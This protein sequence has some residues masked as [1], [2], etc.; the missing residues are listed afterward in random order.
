[1]TATATPTPTP[2]Q[3]AAITASRGPV[4]VVAGPGAGKTFCLIERAHHLIATLG[5]AADRVCAVTFTNK[6]AQEVRQRLRDRLGETAERITGG[7]LHALC[8]EILRERGNPVGV[9]RGFGIA[10]EAYQLQIL[11]RLRVPER[12]RKQLL[13]LFGR[14]RFAAYSLTEGDRRVFSQYEV[15]LRERRLLDF[16]ELVGKTGD[17]FRTYPVAAEEVAASWDA[18]LVDEFQDLD[19][20]QY[21]VIKALASGHRNIFA[22]GDDEQSIFAWRGAE[23]EILRQF[24]RDF[25]I[26]E[27]VVLDRNL[28]CSRR[29]FAVARRLL[30]ANPALFDKRIEAE[31]ESPY[32]VT[33]VEF[34]HEMEEAAWIAHDILADR[35]NSGL[36]LGEYAAL[37]RQHRHAD[38]LEAELLKAGVVCRFARGRALQDDPVIGYLIGSLKIALAPD[39]PALLVLFAERELPKALLNHVRAQSR[40]EGDDVMAQLRAFATTHPKDAEGKRAWRFIYH[41]DNLAAAARAHRSLPALVEALV[42]LRISSWENRLERESD[43]LLDPADDPAA[44]ALADRLIE[45]EREGRWVT[46][47][48]AGGTE[49]PLRSMLGRARVRRLTEGRKDG[50]TE[51][52]NDGTTEGR[53]DGGMDERADEWADRVRIVGAVD[54][55]ADGLP[56]T[57]FRA[58]QLR[59]TRHLGD[60]FQRFVT[61]DLETTGTDTAQCEIVEIGAARVIGDRIV[62]RFQSLVKP[63]GPIAREA[64]RIH[65]ITDQDVAAAPRFPEVWSAFRA[66]VKN[67][68]LVAHNAHQFDLPVLRRAA[69]DL[70][71]G[72]RLHAF[73]TLPVARAVAKGGA[74]LE[75]LAR[76]YGIDPGTSHR[77]LDDA[78]TL[79][80]VFPHLERA[81]IVRARK[82]ALV[83]LLD[84]LALALALGPE[85]RSEHAAFLFELGRFVALGPR[86]VSL[87]TYAERYDVATAI[88]RL[89]G[90]KLMERLRRERT[91]EDLYPEA[92]ERLR[93]F[94]EVEGDTIEEQVRRFLEVMA[95][96]TSSEGDVDQ[97][98][99]NLLTLH[100][101]KGLEFSRVYVVGVED[102]TLP[103]Y[104]AVRDKLEAEIQEGRRLLYVGMTRA[105]DRLVLTRT[106]RRN[107]W[108]RGGGRYLEEMGVEAKE[109]VASVPAAPAR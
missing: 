13:T 105:K 78:L 80:R 56:V 91:A 36:P 76:S 60:A 108:D 62:E 64:T 40:D 16:D 97:H 14:A 79:A 96:S 100:S 37:F 1:V 20:K 29:I 22:V 2:A 61:F 106:R 3:Q 23:P 43:R 109:P 25:G 51:G 74:R 39:D 103:G 88:E 101:T 52:R 47:E 70:P 63:G 66:F 27:P 48:A 21:A 50:R 57:L 31:R 89:G 5:V 95:L 9:E 28:R 90:Q 71:G 58:L 55:G 83:A 30:G 72:D 73:D 65:G 4:L 46:V 15:I 33:A 69:A 85:E 8:A 19:R 81:R 68:V 32:D 45:A 44:A 99:V 26:A 67:D 24:Q 92:M 35:A 10:D 38:P 53:N 41:V 7:T 42:A 98:A 102:G 59:E 87:A 12:H 86:S 75:D 104:K 54:A 94:L 82:S 11:R 93:G 49:I 17:L 107:G 18:I 84:D 77:A 6:A 34:E